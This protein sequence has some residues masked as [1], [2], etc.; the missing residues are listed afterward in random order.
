MRDN[1][2]QTSH[3]TADST[4]SCWWL[5]Q[6]AIWKWLITYAGLAGDWWVI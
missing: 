2:S 4:Q 6:R 5:L 1:T 3:R